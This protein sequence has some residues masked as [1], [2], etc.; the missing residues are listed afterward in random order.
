MAAMARPNP[1]AGGFFLIAAILI[2]FGVGVALG[3]PVLGAL[4]GTLAGVGI[5]V[6]TWLID[7][8]RTGP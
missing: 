7:R 3:Q 8:R 4:V 6:A 2:G 5:A 1:A